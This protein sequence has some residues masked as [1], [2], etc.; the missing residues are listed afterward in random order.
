MSSRKTWLVRWCRQA[1]RTT[2]GYRRRAAVRGRRF[3]MVY[4]P[5]SES[6]TQPEGCA[7][8]VS[9][10]RDRTGTRGTHATE[11]ICAVQGLQQRVHVARRALVLHADKA[12]LLLGVVAVGRV[13]LYRNMEIGGGTYLTKLCHNTPVGSSSTRTNTVTS[14]ASPSRIA[15][16]WGSWAYWILRSSVKR[17]KPQSLSSAM[18]RWCASVENESG[19][20]A[21]V[22]STGHARG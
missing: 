19:Q 2:G 3:V 5:A 22:I 11:V 20:R 9:E 18:K 15:R 21:A 12:S 8:G 1:D 16:A 6:G 17:V 13:R 7:K 10:G 4:H 14:A